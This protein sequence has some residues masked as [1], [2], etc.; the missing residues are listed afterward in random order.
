M[1]AAV[2]LAAA[3]AVLNF[4]W[5]PGQ[6]LDG[7]PAAWREEARSIVLR[8]ELAVPAEF[9]SRFFEPGQYFVRNDSSGRYYSKYGV[10]NALMSLPPLW[11]QAAA[12]E[13]STPGTYPSL[14]AFNLWN[15]ALSALLAALLYHLA[16][17]YTPRVWVRILFVLGTLY[18]S[19]LWFYLRAQSS[20][21]YQA[22]FFAALFLCLARV[23]RTRAWAWLGGAWVFAAALLFTRVSFGLLLPIIA[24]VA[25]YA[26]VQNKNGVRPHFLFLWLVLPPLAAVA[27]IGLVNTVKFGSPLLTGYHTWRPEVTALTGSLADGLWGFLFSPRFS[28]FLHYPLLVLALAGAPGFWRRHRMDAI[29]MAAVAVP[30]LL[31]T[32]KMPLWAGEFGYGPRY[33]LFMVPVLSLPAI[34][35]ADAIIDSIRTWRARAWAAAA[36]ACLA[37]S[38]YLQ[39][40]VNRLGFWTYYEARSVL[41]VAYSDSAADWF[42]D[43]HVG[44][45]CADLLRH[46]RDLTA[47]PWFPEFR[48]KVSPQIAEQYV[49]ELGRIIDRGNWYWSVPRE[50]RN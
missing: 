15:V 11:A 14:L 18:C 8:G 10:M 24:L 45:V 33:L 46:R 6:F 48:R 43:R 23:L 5:M 4:A 32:S 13:L 1:R 35:F 38:A 47:L 42:R 36:L 41:E 44:V 20:E 40:Q 7:D 34:V 28:V 3:V 37:Y 31:L 19:A 17:R 50:A 25:G 16:S 29:A 26:M 12:G 21:L 49:R 22:V 2:I 30:F 39:V 9:A 27:V